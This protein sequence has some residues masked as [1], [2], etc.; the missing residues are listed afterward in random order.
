ML[1]FGLVFGCRGTLAPCAIYIFETVVVFVQLNIKYASMILMR[2]CEA[3]FVDLPR[4][5]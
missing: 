5:T 4:C 3:F 2:N 1:L